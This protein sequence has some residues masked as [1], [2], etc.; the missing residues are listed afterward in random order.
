MDKVVVVGQVLLQLSF[1]V[2]TPHLAIPGHL[3]L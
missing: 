3:R 1:P 2:L